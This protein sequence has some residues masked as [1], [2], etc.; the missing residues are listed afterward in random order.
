[1]N[2]NLSLEPGHRKDLNRSGLLEDT[3]KKAGIKSVPPG[4]ITKKLGADI[5]GLVSAYEIPFGEDYSRF[6]VFYEDGKD[7]DKKGDKKPK[8]MARKGSG[9]RLY[10]PAAAESILND[11]NMP[12]EI[13]EG[14]KKALKACQEGLH[15]IGIT[16][17]WN[18]KVKDESELIE[19]FN[20][21]ALEGRTIFITPDNDWLLPNRKGEHKNLK[22]A[23]DNFAYL[24]IDR[25]AKVF[26]RELPNGRK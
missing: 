21:I 15:C 20:K 10:I 19:C 22:Q 7:V 5:Y 16:G 9:N 14:E 24:L 23:V 2:N 13:T 25:G 26:W 3:I 17:L 4:Q 12:L 1:V 18:W 6:R 11:V 8:Y